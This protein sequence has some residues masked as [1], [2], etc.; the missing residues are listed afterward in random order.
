[1]PLH[2]QNKRHWGLVCVDMET[3]TVWYDDGMKIHP[4]AHLCTL[5]GRLVKLLHEMFPSVNNFNNMVSSHLS[6]TQYKRIGM[7]WQRLDGQT[8]GSGSCGMGVI[9]LAQEIILGER[10]PPHQITWTF[11][12][13]NYH[14]KKLMLHILI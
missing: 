3:L 8:A 1:M 2:M 11:E 13:A 7:P 12:E 5:I 6:T 14:R 4:P 10:V 9:L